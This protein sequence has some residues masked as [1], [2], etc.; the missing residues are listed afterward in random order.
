MRS[1][2][3]SGQ[4]TSEHTPPTAAGQSF[5]IASGETRA[6]GSEVP[7]DGLWNRRMTETPK[8]RVQ[9]IPWE[10]ASVRNKLWC[11]GYGPYGHQLHVS[12]YT[13]TYTQAFLKAVVPYRTGFEK[14]GLVTA[15]TK[16]KIKTTLKSAI[17]WDVGTH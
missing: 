10:T 17:S 4:T 14:G 15:L 2:W 1:K 5:A 12:R 9:I 16:A 13:P 3:P 8:P 11:V 6:I 7:L